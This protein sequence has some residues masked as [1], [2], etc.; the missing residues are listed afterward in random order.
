MESPDWARPIVHWEIE[1]VD[2]EAQRAFYAGLFNWPIGDGPIMG[3][4]A[5]LGGPEPGP[6]GHLRRGER[7]RISLYIQVR[8]LNES[9]ARVPELG[10]RVVSSPFDVPDG[11]TIA[12]IE[13]PEGNALV[14]VQQ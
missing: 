3:V 9:L 14:L 2:P 5:G 7:S 4:P 12:S 1:A 6:A 13:D 8:N 10:G 11:P